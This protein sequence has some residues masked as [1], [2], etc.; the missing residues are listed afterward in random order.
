MM[1]YCSCRIYSVY[2]W[3]PM[4]ATVLVGPAYSLMTTQATKGKAMH[5]VP[6]LEL[7]DCKSHAL[8]IVVPSQ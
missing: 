7:R 3:T 6:H 4:Q 1:R 8:T 5:L 2:I